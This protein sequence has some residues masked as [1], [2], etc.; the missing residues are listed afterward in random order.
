MTLMVCHFRRPGKKNPPVRKRK[1]RKQPL[2]ATLTVRS[3]KILNRN[4]QL[5]TI[6]YQSQNRCLRKKKAKKKTQPEEQEE[7][8]TEKPKKTKKKASTASEEV[9]EVKE[10]KPKK[11]RKKTGTDEATEEEKPKKSKKK[12]QTEPEEQPVETEEEEKPKKVKKKQAEEEED[13]KPKKTKKKNK[14]VED[15][16][17]DSNLEEEPKKQKKKSKPVEES[18]S[19]LSVEDNQEENKDKK[20]L[21]SEDNDEINENLDTVKPK[22]GKKGKKNDD[23]ENEEENENLESD[24]PKRAKKGKKKDDDGDNEDNE[25]PKKGKKGKKKDDD[26]ENGEKPKKGKGKKGK[27]PKDEDDGDVVFEKEEKKRPVDKPAIGIKGLIQILP[28]LYLGN[29]DVSTEKDEL[30]DQGIKYI[31]NCASDDVEDSFA[32]STDFV[33]TNFPLNDTHEA[34]PCDYWERATDIILQAKDE[35]VSVLVH[36]IDG[37]SISGTMILAYMMLS[38]SRKEK[39]LPLMKALDFVLGKEPGAIPSDTF[40]EQLIKLEKELFDSNSVQLTNKK[41]WSSW[42]SESERR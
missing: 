39:E 28:H 13:E 23:D 19:E 33:Y 16:V 2:Q 22:K 42:S 12:I 36:C 17:D 11:N 8:D 15:G 35:D 41:N 1:E 31:I 4:P 7:P 38:A 34:R 32:D 5:Q 14:P 6:Q 40:M 37:K 26:D 27:A 30:L 24:K 20:G 25:K 10:E 21:K 18:M 3:P 29:A 9:E